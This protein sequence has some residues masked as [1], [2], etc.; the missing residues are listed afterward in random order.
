MKNYFRKV[1]KW[2]WYLICAPY[3]ILATLLFLMVSPWITIRIGPLMSSRIGHFAAN[4]ELY[5]LETKRGINLP[6]RR[7]VIDIFFLVQPV[8]NQHLALMWSRKIKVYNRIFL[9]PVWKT[10]R[11]LNRV[12]KTDP[13]RFEPGGTSQSDRDIHNLRNDTNSILSFTDKE[14]IR[15]QKLLRELGIPPNTDFVCLTVRDSAYL[16]SQF[17]HKDWSYHNYRDSE[18]ADYVLAAEALANDD[19]YVV[20]MGAKVHSPIPSKHPKIIDY[21]C[22][23][24]RSDFLDIYLGANC[25]FCI[26]QGTG[27]DAIPILFRKPVVYVNMVPISYFNTFYKKALGIFKHHISTHTGKQLTFNEIFQ[28]GAGQCLSSAC[29]DQKGIILKNNSPEEILDVVLEMKDRVNTDSWKEDYPLSNE[30][31]RFWSL[32]PINARC[33][34]KFIRLHGEAVSLIGG[35]YLE[36]NCRL[37]LGN[38]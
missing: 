35:K 25:L 13:I 4:T 17:P 27:F 11:I 21:P 16:A 3:A 31:R 26:S 14:E 30:Q 6:V 10:N 15:G 19:I 12:L 34:S 7:K 38:I 18:I 20:R 32:F 8:C 37:L 33:E 36:N 29:F 1:F 2:G 22:S 24:M 9:L 23:G 5:L 28:C